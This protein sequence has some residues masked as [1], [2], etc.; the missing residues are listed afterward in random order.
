MERSRDLHSDHP[1][2]TGGIDTTTT[3]IDRAPATSGRTT[4]TNRPVNVRR[5]AADKHR[6]KEREKRKA[7]STRWHGGGFGDSPQRKRE[8]DDLRRFEDLAEHHELPDFEHALGASS[9]VG[10]VAAGA[11][12]PWFPQAKRARD[13]RLELARD[14]AE[15]CSA[16]AALRCG[17]CT[18]GERAFRDRCFSMLL[19]LARIFVAPIADRQHDWLIAR[20][21]D[22]GALLGCGSRNAF[23]VMRH[24]H[25]HH[26]IR[27]V[28]DYVPE[29]VELPDGTIYRR[30]T[31]APNAYALADRA[32]HVLGI[33]SLQ[34]IRNCEASEPQ[35]VR[36]EAPKSSGLEPARGAGSKWDG[37]PAPTPAPALAPLERLNVP[38]GSTDAP[39]MA[40]VVKTR[41]VTPHR[42]EGESKSRAGSSSHPLRQLCVYERREFT[43]ADA[44][45]PAAVAQLERQRALEQRK[46]NSPA[47][48][49]RAAAMLRKTEAERTA[50][51]QHGADV[52]AAELV[53]DERK[54]LHNIAAAK[55]ADLERKRADLERKRAEADAATQRALTYAEMFDTR[56]SAAIAASPEPSRVDEP[57]DE[58]A[59]MNTKPST[60][61]SPVTDLY[62]EA[63]L[64]ELAASTPRP[65]P[66]PKTDDRRETAALIR[67][68]FER[69]F[70]G[71]PVAAE[72]YLAD[73]QRHDDDEGG[74]AS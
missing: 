58:L 25:R 10:L 43:V 2:P 4:R 67:S 28:P 22:V 50:L 56:A 62:A 32:L 57:T 55:L 20:H 3:P 16:G 8:M 39:V 36:T 42:S 40:L 24:L 35:G 54:Q 38:D 74:G 26:W 7:D 41:P 17:C 73:L 6:R 53:A 48:A 27:R 61:A 9:L 66:R 47:H 70:G 30:H 23:E 37:A 46:H 52:A 71:V 12:T 11:V 15:P 13:L 5:G 65:P 1:P 29:D 60:A 49:L 21:V 68:A 64:A 51:I 31:R 14:F 34:A 18:R 59:A 69:K 72:S 33:V 19:W 63:E 44:F 45:D